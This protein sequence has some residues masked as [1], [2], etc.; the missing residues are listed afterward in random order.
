MR[1]KEILT[2]LK[3]HP[4]IIELLATAQDERCLYFIFEVGKNGNLFELCS[5]RGKKHTN[6]NYFYR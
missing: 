1:E 2:M 6:F 3:G 5:K 4:N